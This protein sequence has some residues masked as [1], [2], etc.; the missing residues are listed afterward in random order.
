MVFLCFSFSRSIWGPGLSITLYAP[1]SL[2]S[3]FS[4]S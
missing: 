2:T 1:D 4:I 3:S